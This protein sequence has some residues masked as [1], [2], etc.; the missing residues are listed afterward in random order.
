MSKSEA[1]DKSRINLTDTPEQIREKVKKSVTDLTS[2]VTYDP[3]NR[4]G[5]SNLIGMHMALTDSFVEDIVEESY[6]LAEDTNLYKQRLA[7]IIIAKLSPIRAEILKL[8]TD[9]GYLLN[10]LQSG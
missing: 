3:V 8:N 5:V 9:K 6:L 1:S 4:P 7:D 2:E 10:V